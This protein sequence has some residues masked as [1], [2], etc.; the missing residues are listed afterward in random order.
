MAL[1]IELNFLQVVGA[2][3]AP[4]V[5]LRDWMEYTDGKR[6][7]RLGTCFEVLLLNNA[8]T[9]LTVKVEDVASPIEQQELDRRNSSLNFVSV[10]F[11]G[12]K[13]RPYADSKGQMQISAKAAK[14]I[15]LNR[16]V[17]A[18]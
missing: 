3:S 14:I 5:S 15:F 13:A 12:F 7:K 2:D 4:L 1:N 6:G 10:K 18:K 16:E 17:A 9:K 11:D 8:C